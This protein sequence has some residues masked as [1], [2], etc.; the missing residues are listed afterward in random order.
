[1]IDYLNK[2]LYIEILAS[3]PGECPEI[4]YESYDRNQRCETECYTDADCSERNKCCNIGCSKTCIQPQFPRA[5]T[6]APAFTVNPL[7]GTSK[8][9]ESHILNLGYLIT[10]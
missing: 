1:M 3:K 5:Y 7:A 6:S 2:K 4:D 10:H 8:I 9:I